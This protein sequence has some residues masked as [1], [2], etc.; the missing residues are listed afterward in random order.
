M[1]KQKERIFFVGNE[2]PYPDLCLKKKHLERWVK[3]IDPDFM[4]SSE[5]EKEELERILDVF[6][7]MIEAIERRNGPPCLLAVKITP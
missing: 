5:E 7:E 4:A 3:A 6:C 1:E 2:W